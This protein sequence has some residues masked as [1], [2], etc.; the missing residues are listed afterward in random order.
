MYL[1]NMLSDSPTV[2]LVEDGHSERELFAIAGEKAGVRFSL[3]QAADGLEALD[4]LN[5]HSIF[6]DRTAYPFPSLVILDLNMPK[7]SGF[8]VLQWIRSHPSIHELP[9]IMWTSS[10]SEA[11]IRRAYSLAANSYLVKPMS[12]GL[13]V[14]MVRQIEDY[15]LKLNHLPRIEPRSAPKSSLA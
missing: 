7:M 1:I 9:V 6:A 14:D 13:L 10:T 5:G 12:I 4:Y 8:E 3:R 11:D 2:L 15:W